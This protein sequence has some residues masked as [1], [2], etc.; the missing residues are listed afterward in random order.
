MSEFA[1]HSFVHI[2]SSHLQSLSVFVFVFLGSA[3]CVFMFVCLCG[4]VSVMSVSLCVY[5]CLSAC[6][7]S[8]DKIEEEVT[9]SLFF[10]F[11]E[12]RQE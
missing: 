8:Y 7:L 5:V 12:R 6:A 3:S 9:C 10:E 11:E 1:F 2:L 4:C